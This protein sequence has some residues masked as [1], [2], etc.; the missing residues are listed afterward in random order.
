MAGNKK[1]GGDQLDVCK[2][3]NASEWARNRASRWS[4]VRLHVHL[5]VVQKK[6]IEDMD[7]GT[8][9]DIKHHV[10]HNPLINWLARMYD[11][12]SRE[13][14]IPG[15]GRIPLNADSIYRTLGLPRGEIPMVDAIDDVIEI[16]LGRY[17]LAIAV[18]RRLLVSLPCWQR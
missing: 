10:L 1:H 13:F 3:L 17:F 7:L 6:G 12:L 4:V 5:S 14:V 2:M 9:L 8:L 18:S 16:F 11:K 15:H